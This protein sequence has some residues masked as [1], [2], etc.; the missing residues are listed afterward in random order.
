M[1]LLSFFLLLDFAE[2]LNTLN[3]KL[4][5]LEDLLENLD[6]LVIDRLMQQIIKTEP[7]G[8]NQ[9]ETFV[10]LCR[11]IEQYFVVILELQA[12][13]FNIVD[14]SHLLLVE[15]FPHFEHVFQMLAGYLVE[16]AF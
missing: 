14:H 16:M 6:V 11:D 4:E 12:V 8:N 2:L 10:K 9:H 7:T 13:V 3:K 5:L 15:E 1:E